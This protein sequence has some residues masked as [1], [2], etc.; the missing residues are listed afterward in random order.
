MNSLSLFSRRASRIFLFL[1]LPLSARAAVSVLTY[2]NDL[3]R[4]GANTNETVLTPGNVNSTTFG[5]V[6]AC[7]VDGYVYGE[8]LVLTNV[9]I[10][11]KGTHNV[12]FVATEH[13]SVYA[14]DADNNTGANGAPLW[15]VNFL[16]PAAGVTTLPNVDVKSTDI[17]P[18]IGITSTP[19]IDAANNAIFV[20]AKTKE[21]TG[22][23]LKNPIKDSVVSKRGSDLQQNGTL[24]VA[25]DFPQDLGGIRKPRLTK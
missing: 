6:F 4:T 13:D 24:T 8:P 22:G 2:H 12:V 5:K 18:E 19:V 21:I 23:K 14:F 3:A 9:A 7:P 16:N 11:G 17:V 25:K 10:A 1:L 15:Q 20:E